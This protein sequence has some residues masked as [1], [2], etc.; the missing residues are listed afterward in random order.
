MCLRVA[1]FNKDLVA[2]CHN[3]ER[4]MECAM[5]LMGCLSNEDYETLKEDWNKAGGVKVI[6]WWEFIFNNV[7]VKYER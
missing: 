3:D 2:E 1:K 5:M 7:T 4:K 6:K